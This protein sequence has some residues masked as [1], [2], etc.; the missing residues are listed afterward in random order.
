MVLTNKHKRIQYAGI[1]IEYDMEFYE[2]KECH[3]KV[4]TVEQASKAQWAM[5][6]AY[7]KAIDKQ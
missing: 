4:G 2:C 3:L 7:R 6:E 5:L 1:Q